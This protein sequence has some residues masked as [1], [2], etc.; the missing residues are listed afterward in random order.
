MNFKKIQTEHVAV[1][2]F[3]YIITNKAVKCVESESKVDPAQSVAFKTVPSTRSDRYYT[4]FQWK[5]HLH[6]Q[7]FL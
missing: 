3:F 5:I 6:R 4:A 1:T 7:L 2:K